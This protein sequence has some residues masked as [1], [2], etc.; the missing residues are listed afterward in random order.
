MKKPIVL[1]A[2]ALSF[3]LSAQSWACGTWGHHGGADGLGAAI[4]DVGVM[5]LLGV[6]AVGAFAFMAAWK[7]RN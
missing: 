3:L 1:A 5:V 2:F 6:G 4:A 7:F